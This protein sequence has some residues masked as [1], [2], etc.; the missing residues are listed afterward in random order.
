MVKR[1]S[2]YFLRQRIRCWAFR[3]RTVPFVTEALRENRQIHT[4]DV[5]DR[6][7]GLV[8]ERGRFAALLLPVLV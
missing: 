3:L 1:Q 7:E 5:H 2:T 6:D 8:N 4:K